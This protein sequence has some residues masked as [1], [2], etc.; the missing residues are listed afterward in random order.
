MDNKNIEYTELPPNTIKLNGND[1]GQAMKEINYQQT[2][3]GEKTVKVVLQFPD[4]VYDAITIQKEV[5]EILVQALHE[6]IQRRDIK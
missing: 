5:H 2:G 1:A 4:N 3:Y 6:Q